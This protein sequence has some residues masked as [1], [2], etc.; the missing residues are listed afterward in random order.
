[1]EAETK[2]RMQAALE[3]FKRE[4]SNLRT[5]R[6]NPHILDGVMVEA[7]GTQMRLRDLA[8]VT[9]PEPRQILI[10]PYDGQVAG[11]IS[12]GIEKANLNLQPRLEG[13]IVRILIPP[14]DEAARKEIVKQ[15]KK[16][17]EDAKVALREIRRRQNESV[18]KQKADGEITEDIQK[19]TEKQIQEL[20]D[21][22]CKEID[23]LF[24]IKEKEIMTV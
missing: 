6:A 12:K 17:A 4:L 24:D 14:L 7:Y 1:M 2:S 10:T 22:F 21:T 20:T 9:T 19:K 13:N 15:G 5:G 8:N 23:T 11:A 3:H 18:R 16:K